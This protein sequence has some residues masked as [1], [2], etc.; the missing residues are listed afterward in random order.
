MPTKYKLSNE[1]IYWIVNIGYE[2]HTVTELV[3]ITGNVVTF[4]SMWQLLKKHNVSAVTVQTRA[5]QTILKMHERGKL[6][7]IMQAHKDTGICYRLISKIVHRHKLPLKSKRAKSVLK[8]RWGKTPYKKQRKQ[9][10]KKVSEFELKK[11]AVAQMLNKERA[12]W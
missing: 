10:V 6:R 1:I 3:N 5:E 9:Q 7:S 4:A 12:K 11:Q 2:K 8:N